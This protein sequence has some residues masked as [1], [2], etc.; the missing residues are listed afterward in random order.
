MMQ[1]KN[2]V[3]GMESMRKVTKSAIISF[4]D[5]WTQQLEKESSTLVNKFILK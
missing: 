2:T 4:K 5:I 1:F 3:K